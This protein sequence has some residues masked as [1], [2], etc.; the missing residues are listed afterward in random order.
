[1][2]M[3]KS[4]GNFIEPRVVIDKFGVDALRFYV[5][6]VNPPWDDITFQ[7]E[8]VRTA[9]RSLN[10]LWNVLRFATTYMTLDRFDPST[11][12]AKTIESRLRH[13]DRWVLS[14]LP[15]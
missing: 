12:D 9:Q 4:L 5:L 7:E 14:R 13:K 2:Q 6:A 11:A 1:R 10:I 15:G 8:G 3:H